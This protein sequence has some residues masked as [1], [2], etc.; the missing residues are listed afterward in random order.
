MKEVR[1]PPGNVATA[2]HA[3]ENDSDYEEP[4]D[5]SSG[6]NGSKSDTDADSAKQ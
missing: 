1:D 4:Q 3:L 2:I 5:A 6:S